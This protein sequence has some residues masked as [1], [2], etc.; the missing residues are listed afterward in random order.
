MPHKPNKSWSLPEL[1]Q[2]V[3]DNKLADK[4]IR[5]GMKKAEMVMALKKKG[6]FDESHVSTKEF[7]DA[8]KGLIK[9]M[10]REPGKK[11]KTPKKVPM[12]KLKKTYLPSETA[13]AIMHQVLEDQVNLTANKPMVS[14]AQAELQNMLASMGS[15]TIDDEISNM[16]GSLPVVAT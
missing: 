7:K 3:R 11:R 1:K 13:T 4:E 15:F 8:R 10:A 16:M 12:G 14:P 2:Y 6:H 5:L 9:I